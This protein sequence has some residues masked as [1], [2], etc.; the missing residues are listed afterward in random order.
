LCI[1]YLKKQVIKMAKKVPIGKQGLY[2]N[3]DFMNTAD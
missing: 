3:I 1:W 2:F